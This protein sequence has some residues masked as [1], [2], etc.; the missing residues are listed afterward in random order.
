MNQVFFDIKTL[1]EIIKEDMKEVVLELVKKAAQKVEKSNFDPNQ[2]IFTLKEASEY[3]RLSQS[4]IRKRV[5]AGK[6]KTILNT[7][8]GMK[9]HRTELDRFVTDYR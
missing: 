3:L 4:A 1:R 8:R 7:V 9:F 6:I 2:Q 5:R